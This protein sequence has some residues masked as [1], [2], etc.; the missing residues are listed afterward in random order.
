MKELLK[1]DLHCHT[2]ASPDGGLT[3]RDI[4]NVLKSG[5]LDV[6]AVTDHNVVD[7]ALRL[8]AVF[9]DSIIVGEEIMTTDG[10]II[11]LFLRELVPAGLSPKETVK[12]IKKQNGIVYIPHPFE[13]AR[14][15]ISLKSL[16]LIAE[17]VDIVE[18]INGRSFSSKSQ[19]QASAWAKNNNV[20]SF[21]SSDAHGKIGWGKVYTE[22]KEKPTKNSLVSLA[23]KG[24]M[25]GNKN[26]LV[27]YLYPKFNKIRYRK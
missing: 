7:E 14:S 12:L 9:G 2:V 13:K 21:A 18:V 26:G 5:K 6:V 15:G 17:E 10:E 19:K 16:D 25:R 24:V 1:V 22:L 11:G 27:S 20:V 3:E 23:A 4:V 8:N